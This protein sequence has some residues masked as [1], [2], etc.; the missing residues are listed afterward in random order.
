MRWEVGEWVPVEVSV[1]VVEARPGHLDLDAAVVVDAVGE[2]AFHAPFLA[3][4]GRA[5]V[6]VVETGGAPCAT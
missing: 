4:V 1:C 2:Y 6:L 3:A 5:G